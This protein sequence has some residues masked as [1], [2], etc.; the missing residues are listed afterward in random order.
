MCVL[1]ENAKLDKC[2]SDFRWWCWC[3][4]RDEE[5]GLEDT[6]IVYIM[7]VLVVWFKQK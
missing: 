5:E 2:Y 4:W 1:W 7:V 6:G 3:V